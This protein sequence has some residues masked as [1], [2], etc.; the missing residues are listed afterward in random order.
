M[1]VSNL[2]FYPDRIQ[3]GSLV[4]YRHEW[5]S[6]EETSNLG[7]IIG[8]IKT[9]LMRAEIMIAELSAAYVRG[10]TTVSVFQRAFPR[11]LEN[12]PLSAM[13]SAAALSRPFQPSAF[14]PTRNRDSDAIPVGGFSARDALRNSEF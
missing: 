11:S 10:P 14:H 5:N 4:E 3:V 8:S 2:R 9:S 7:E 13:L 1:I 12:F 6:T